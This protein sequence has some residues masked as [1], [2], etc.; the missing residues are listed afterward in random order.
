M[1]TLPAFAI[2]VVPE[3]L[4]KSGVCLMLGSVDCSV[5]I[6]ITAIAPPDIN[7]ETKIDNG[8]KRV[9]NVLR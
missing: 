1:R 2:T 9:F 4:A 5:R 6:G 8:N 3:P 7:D